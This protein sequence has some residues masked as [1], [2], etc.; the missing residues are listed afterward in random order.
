M[1]N[2]AVGQGLVVLHLRDEVLGLFDKH[3]LIRASGHRVIRRTVPVKPSLSDQ[4]L[5]I[6]L[7][8]VGCHSN[9]VHIAEI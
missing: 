1:S 7:G 8:L 4:T 9:L 6:G 2:L 5:Q 3:D